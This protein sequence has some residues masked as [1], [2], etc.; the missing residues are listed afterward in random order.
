MTFLA[1]ERWEKR[2]KAEPQVWRTGAGPVESV[3]GVEGW[4][5]GIS[6]HISQLQL[7]R[8][9]LAQVIDESPSIYP[10]PRKKALQSF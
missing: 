1:H 8:L 4:S 6:L 2:P 5:W 3:T 10:A 7:Y 9:S